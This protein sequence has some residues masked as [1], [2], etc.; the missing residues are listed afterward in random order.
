M[1][2]PLYLEICRSVLEESYADWSD[3]LDD[4]RTALAYFSTAFWLTIRLGK[5]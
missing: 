4:A 5:W 3:F 1:G 2:A